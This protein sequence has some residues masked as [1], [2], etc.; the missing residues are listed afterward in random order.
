MEE[1]SSLNSK[2]M[3][4]IRI[5]KETQLLALMTSTQLK[6]F[7]TLGKVVDSNEC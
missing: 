7:P 1:I 5:C 3:T 4:P 2:M 6:M